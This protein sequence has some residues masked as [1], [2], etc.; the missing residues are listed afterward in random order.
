MLFLQIK[1]SLRHVV[2][3]IRVTAITWFLLQ[4]VHIKPE[5]AIYP[6]DWKA[7]KLF[8]FLHPCGNAPVHA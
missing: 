5:E 1:A 2:S 4:F 6:W 7:T 8:S 3:C